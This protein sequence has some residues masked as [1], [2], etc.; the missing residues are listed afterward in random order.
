MTYLLI[1]DAGLQGIRRA[2]EG[3]FKL[4]VPEFAVTQ[5]PNVSLT[6]GD[7]IL[8]GPEVYRGGIESVEAVG[9]STVKYTLTIP[10]MY[11]ASGEWRIREI[12][13]FLESGELFAHGI[14][15]F[16]MQKTAEFGIKFYVYVTAGRLGEVINVTYTTT[17]SVS[18]TPHVRS[19][20]HPN[21]SR[22][23]VVAVLDEVVGGDNVSSASLA[24][25]YGT[26]SLNWAFVGYKRMA[27]DYPTS[28]FSQGSFV[29]E[30][31]TKGGFWLND[32]EVV[33][34]QIVLGPGQGESR[35]MKFSKDANTFT[36][37]DKNFSSIS[38]QSKVAVW[39]DNAIALPA[40]TSNMPE[41]LVLGV[42]KNTWLPDVVTLGA[43]TLYPY[44][45]SHEMTGNIVDTG[46]DIPLSAYNDTTKFLV[47]VDGDL[48]PSNQYTAAGG[49]V[50]TTV[51]ATRSIDVVAFEFI[52]DQ[53]SSLYFY[54]AVY[55][56]DGNTSEFQ[57]P[58]IPDNAANTL[59]FD[60]GKLV[61]MAE[62]VL[63][64]SQIIFNNYAPTGKVVLVPFARY[65][66]LG[67]RSSLVRDK[68]TT[69]GS[70][71]DFSCTNVFGLRKDTLMLVNGMYV[72]KDNYTVSSNRLILAASYSIPAG[73]VVEII[74]FN[75]QQQSIESQPSGQDTG[76]QWID[77]AGVTGKPNRLVPKLLTYTGDGAQK[78]FD[79]VG[80]PDENYLFVFIHGVF[81]APNSYYYS[82]LA[83]RFEDP[84]PAD[85]PIDIICWQSEPHTGTQVKSK[86]T[87]ITMV[88]GTLTYTVSAITNVD[89]L[90]VSINGVYQHRST[91]II[92]SATTL[93]FTESTQGDL[94]EVWSF[95]WEPKNGYMTSIAI[96]EQNLTTN[97]SY[98]LEH[99]LATTADSLLFVGG[100]QVHKANRYVVDNGSGI[101]T[102]QLTNAPFNYQQALPMYIVELF[103]GKPSSRLMT[104]QEV[105]G[106]Y[107]PLR[108]PH[109]SWDNLTDKLKAILACPMLKLL[110]LLTGTIKAE[111]NNPNLN[112]DDKA[113]VQKWGFTPVKMNVDENIIPVLNYAAIG[114]SVL[115]DLPVS[116]NF[117]D[118]LAQHIR[119]ELGVS[120]FSIRN[121]EAGK[122][123][124]IDDIRISNVTFS[125]ISRT[126]I[127]GAPL[128]TAW[129]LGAL[130]GL[131]TYNN[132][133]HLSVNGVYGYLL[134]LSTDCAWWIS[135]VGNAGVNMGAGDYAHITFEN[136]SLHT[137]SVNVTKDS[138]YL[139]YTH[140]IRDNAYSGGAAQWTVQIRR[141]AVIT[142]HNAQF[143]TITSA[144]GAP[145]YV[146]LFARIYASLKYNDQ[147]IRRV[148][149]C[150][151]RPCTSWGGTPGVCEA[152]HWVQF[153]AMCRDGT[154]ANAVGGSAVS[155]Q[156]PAAASYTAGLAFG[157]RVY[158]ANY[159][160]GD[161][162]VV[163]YLTNGSIG[164]SQ[165]GADLL[166][167]SVKL[168]TNYTVYP[169]MKV[170]PDG[171]V[172]PVMSN[173]DL[174]DSCCWTGVNFTLK[175]NCAS[176]TP[177]LPPDQAPAPAVQISPSSVAT[178]DHLYITVSNVKA[179][180][181][182]SWEV[183][184][185]PNQVVVVGN[186]DNT[187]YFSYTTI[188]A[189][190]PRA[191]TYKVYVD[192][193]YLDTVGVT[194]TAAGGSVASHGSV[195]FVTSGSFTVP[196]NIYTISVEELGAGGGGAGGDHSYG[197]TGGARGQ[198]VTSTVSV[199]PGEVLEVV[200][201]TGGQ[202]GLGCITEPGVANNGTSGTA[203]ILK[204]QNGTAALTANG[205]IGGTAASHFGGGTNGQSSEMGI[206]GGGGNAGNPTFDPD[207]GALLNYTT[208]GSG[209][210]AGGYGAGGGGGGASARDIADAIPGAS[211]GLGTKG[212]MRITY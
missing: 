202:S 117:Y 132:T 109:V 184:D 46:S 193:A 174:F 148:I 130:T 157:T 91:Y 27:C 171:T 129:R 101:S 98:L 111:L 159:T 29:Y 93:T 123:Y 107:M 113:V 50:T 100:A 176:E 122:K 194:V 142:N 49:V 77:P 108:G 62:Y 45:S 40:R 73:S 211:G 64:G 17:A 136:G 26:G 153:S 63:N 147:D 116:F 212:W 190:A 134:C 55:Q 163:V 89:S 57:L 103:S 11:P 12:G 99:Q 203:T 146:Q 36:T 199:V 70:E 185:T 43:G 28:I 9:I 76:P 167:N 204:H 44:R 35:K 139:Y 158:D 19:L 92:D 51:S 164:Y 180:A 192:G 200:I 191:L 71:V 131:A 32:E 173:N 66:E 170:N 165:F 114:S 143:L 106:Y 24:I 6:V 31:E 168:P 59:V 53:G 65:D 22:Q 3:G 182:I 39:R 74:N 208:P 2:D 97:K 207:T 179:G 183:S 104:R 56:G 4:N 154:V 105:E 42:G 110:G 58:I 187:G 68:F 135:I 23:N 72:E 195:E 120:D 79:I 82:S 119:T 30:V 75:G 8:Q 41:Y 205:G 78:T 189:G 7:T 151:N 141:Q 156:Y 84:V 80:V 186:A 21:E 188:P 67:I 52:Q 47:F 172:D 125:A 145:A 152:F 34:V 20:L 54:E 124:V 85:Y 1:T 18:S 5:E 94:L 169:G 96:E 197:G 196:N 15:P 138:T 161:A 210:N 112:N 209:G 10:S 133:S 206:G 13:L 127:P 102:I 48:L 90:V 177:A 118:L 115:L 14:T 198:Y 16:A 137:V 83:I 160:T 178:T 95:D 38:L 33:I 181:V 126:Q 166:L 175:P 87:S 61:A 81:Q 88:S 149:Q 155:S 150:I 201:G 69:T 60:S 162:K 86:Y 37:V 140:V 25:K 121:Y 128:D 144:G